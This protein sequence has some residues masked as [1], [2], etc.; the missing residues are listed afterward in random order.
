VLFPKPANREVYGYYK[1]D[2]AI[3]RLTAYNQFGQKII[4]IKRPPHAID[5]SMLLPGLYFIE[6]EADDYKEITKLIIK[7]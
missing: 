5:V 7:E 1:N 4:N 3:D 2:L 6:T